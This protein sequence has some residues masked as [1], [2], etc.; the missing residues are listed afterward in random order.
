MGCLGSS[1]T[2]TIVNTNLCSSNLF[3]DENFRDV[4]L[5]DPNS[6]REDW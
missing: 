6:Q 4:F 5:G 1:N 3:R 2:S